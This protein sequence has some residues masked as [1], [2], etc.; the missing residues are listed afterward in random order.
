[1]ITK[2]MKIELWLLALCIV[3]IVCIIAC[4]GNETKVIDPEQQRLEHIN[5]IDSTTLRTIL[6]PDTIEGA[7]KLSELTAEYWMLIDDSTG[8]VI[9]ERNAD[10]LAYMASLTKMMTCLLA[11]EKGTMTD[12]VEITQ[13]VFVAK[14]SR[15]KLGDSFEMRHLVD[16]MMLVSDNDAAYAL[17]KHIGG[18]TLKFCA[19][20]NDKAISLGMGRTH[21]ANPNG[22][23]NKDNYST[24]CDLIKLSRYCMSDSSFAQIVGTQEKDIPF[25]D[26]RHMPCRNTNALLST[27]EGCIGIKTGFTRQA[28]NCLAS[29]ATRDGVTLYLVLLNSR[30]MSSR[31]TES[32]ILLDYGFNVMKRCRR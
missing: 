32:A 21:F 19:M 25:V 14:D 31:F 9:S 16:E 4:S 8:M 17:A 29:A 26:G 15:V 18:D 12:T 23:P 6:N 5:R 7:E 10:S 30:S 22:M 1:M 3:V 24:A 11:L 2:D 20:M 27:Y 13:D 28:G